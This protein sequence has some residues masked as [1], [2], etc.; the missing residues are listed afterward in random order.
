MGLEDGEL[1]FLDLDGPA[2]GLGR[3]GMA[4]S[5]M[6]TARLRSRCAPDLGTGLNQLG[7]WVVVR[8]YSI[9][10]LVD[11][12][13]VLLRRCD[14][15]AEAPSDHATSPDISNIKGASESRLCEKCFVKTFFE[16]RGRNADADRVYFGP[17]W[18]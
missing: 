5:G 6:L 12:I 11:R 9:R 8:L 3:R 10:R 15:P 18:I 4:F 1:Q 13:K 7:G 2:S 17:V 16:T 14:L